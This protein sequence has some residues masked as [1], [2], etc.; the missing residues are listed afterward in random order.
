MN[1]LTR[2]IAQ[3]IVDRTMKIL[4]RNINVMDENGVI[5]GSGDRSRIGKIHEGA[6]IVIKKKERIDI[7]EEESKLLTGVK[8]G[9]NF[10]IVFED[11]IVGV[12][13]ISGTPADISHYGELVKMGAE[14]T[15]Q[16]AFLAEQLQWDVRLKEELVNQ[17]IHNEIDELAMERAIRFEI[18]L[19]IP[20]IAV[21]FEVVQES[22]DEE[23]ITKVKKQLM[24][25]LVDRLQK[26]DLV[27]STSSRNF[28]VLKKVNQQ[29]QKDKMQIVQEVKE[30]M[31]WFSQSKSIS[32]K[33]GIGIEYSSMKGAHNSYERAK[34]GLRVG[35]ILYPGIDIYNYDDLVLPVLLSQISSNETTLARYYELIVQNDK[36]GELQETLQQFIE[37]NGELNQVAAKL[38]IHR[39]TL[40]YRLSKI[41]EI[42]GKDPRKIKELLELYQSKY[43][44][45]LKP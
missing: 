8:P 20:R 29:T 24:A 43:L 6:L 44:Y 18:D 36:K 32:I 41:H 37:E 31:K 38:F 25:Q 23:T 33:V 16:Q 28:V 26:E 17:M 11:Q 9:I 3:E 14:M 1:I 35:K 42:S 5:I 2:T 30:M 21:L 39:N 45:Q 34:Q 15:L 40:R 10:P 27:A 13:G 22:L 12:I 7:Q 4:S 19:S